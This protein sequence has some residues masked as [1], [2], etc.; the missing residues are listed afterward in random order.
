MYYIGSLCISSIFDVAY[1]I[2][3]I[4]IGIGV[5]LF[6][7]KEWGIGEADAV[8]QGGGVTG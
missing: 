5:C 7:L 3:G 8:I 2:C 4:G 6:V 1:W